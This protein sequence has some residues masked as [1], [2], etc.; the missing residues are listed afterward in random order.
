M[1]HELKITLEIP[2]DLQND[3]LSQNDETLS[4]ERAIDQNFHSLFGSGAFFVAYLI[5]SSGLAKIIIENIKAKSRKKLTIKYKEELFELNISANGL[6][7]KDVM[8]I[9]DAIRKVAKN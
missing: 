6:S 4:F 8:E 9:L 3:V 1:A 7:K 2:Q 5:G